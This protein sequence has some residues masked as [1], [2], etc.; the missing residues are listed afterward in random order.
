[1]EA[2]IECCT[3]IFS[4]EGG[5]VLP[6]SEKSLQTIKDSE[7]KL[8]QLDSVRRE[9]EVKAQLSAIYNYSF[10]DVPSSMKG[11]EG[12]GRSQCVRMLRFA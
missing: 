2:S 3:H 5:P 7:E 1:M 12:T 6:I 8:R 4:D 9:V 10:I 11:K